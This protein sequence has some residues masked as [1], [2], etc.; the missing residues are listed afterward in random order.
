MFRWRCRFSRTCGRRGRRREVPDWR[1]G[2]AQLVDLSDN[3]IVSLDIPFDS[4]RFYIPQ[5]ALDEMANEAG[6]RRVKGT[7]CAE[8]WC[9]RFGHVRSGASAR[10]R[11]GAARRRNR[12]VF[13]L[14]RACFFR[15]HRARLRRSVR[16]GDET[17]VAALRRGSCGAPATSSMPIW[18]V[19]LRS[20]R[21]RMSADYRAAISPGLSSRRRV[22]HHS[23]G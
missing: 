12:D 23:A 3:P 20:P 8:F 13:R 5:I 19:I 18:E 7:L 10:R 22:S 1:L 17:S 15:S 21:S 2:D 6:I 4:L 9:P 14:Y 11:D 16:P